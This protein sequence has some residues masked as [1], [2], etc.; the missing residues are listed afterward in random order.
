MKEAIGGAWIYTIVLIFIAVFTCF[1]SVS[2]NYSRCFRIKDEILT[3]IEMYHGINE[4]TIT[5]IN[6]Y[7]KG[8]GYAST[9]TCP[10]DGTCWYRFSTNSN[11]RIAGYGQKV[12]YCL[13]KT[14]VIEPGGANGPIG[15]I[16]SAYY[17]VVVFF[18]LDWPILR[19]FFNINIAG[20]TSIIYMPKN[21]FDQVTENK[22]R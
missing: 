9:G 1:I 20:E 19:Q 3:T 10:D 4:Q 21:E 15:H 2:T 22:C 12:N 7:L 8:I 11:N 6:D 14:S 13:A 17:K 5:K 18:K 16:E